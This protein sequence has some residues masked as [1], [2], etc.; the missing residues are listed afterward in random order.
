MSEKK[1]KYIEFLNSKYGLYERLIKIEF[2]LAFIL[3]FF[4]GFLIYESLIGTFDAPKN[5]VIG[6]VSSVFLILG[7]Y[8]EFKKKDIVKE[9]VGPKT[10]KADPVLL[11]SAFG[12]DISEYSEVLVHSMDGM[13]VRVDSI[14][15]NLADLNHK[16]HQ[17]GEDIGKIYQIVSQLATE[18]VKLM[19]AVGKTS[20]EIHIMLEIVTLVIDAITGKNTAME[21][22]VTL[23]KSGQEKVLRTNEIIKKIRESSGSILKLIDFINNVSKETNLLAINAAIEATHSGSE[24]KGFTVIAEEIRNLATETAQNAREINKILKSNIEDYAIADNSSNDSAEAFRYIASEIHTIHGTIAEVVQSIQELKTRG[25]EILGK[26]KTLDEVAERVRDTSGEVYGEIVN[27]NANLDEIQ[28]LSD[29]IQLESKEI[30]E[31]QEWVGRITKK[32]REKIEAITQQTD[33]FLKENL[34]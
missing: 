16:L 27:V 20:E 28:T 30:E 22:M 32:M 10:Q 12:V 14:T 8:L 4:S 9:I 34:M 29:Q 11:L 23:S 25:E 24:G 5:L 21:N 6:I 15:K 2:V 3:I 26:A 18:E 1:L 13:K 19:E 33:E 17:T 7:L 31:S